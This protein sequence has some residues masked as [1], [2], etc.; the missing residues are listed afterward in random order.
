MGLN[1]CVKNYYYVLTA[2]VTVMEYTVIVIILLFLLLYAKNYSALIHN[3]L[4][5]KMDTKLK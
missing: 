2:Y 5:K 4:S 1:L 3:L